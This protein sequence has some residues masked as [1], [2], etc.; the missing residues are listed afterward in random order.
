[1][2]RR[3]K[4]IIIASF[5]LAFVTGIASA[6]V[7][8]T[9]KVNNADGS[10][11]T[12]N[13]NLPTTVRNPITGK[14]T[15]TGK[16]APKTTS[17]STTMSTTTTTVSTN[18]TVPTTTNTP[19]SVGLMGW[20]V[21]AS[22][23][24]LAAKGLSCNLLQ[25]YSGPSK[26]QAGQTYSL[27]RFEQ[28]VDL[29]A[30]NVIL[31]RVCVRPRNQ[32]V[33]GSLVST[34]V[35]APSGDC[36]FYGLP[37]GTTATV[38]DSEIDGS[39]IAS[40]DIA[41]A[42]GFDGAANLYRNYVHHTGSGIAL[43]ETGTEQSFVVEN[44]YVHMLRHAGD[45]HHDGATVRDFLKN[46]NNTRTLLWKNN[47]F[48]SRNDSGEWETAAF[49]LQPTWSC[50]SINN[51]RLEGNLFEGRAYNL[52]LEQHNG[53]HTNS[54]AVNNRFWQPSGCDPQSCYGHSLVTGS[55]GWAVWQDNYEYDSTR[56]DG[57]GA[58]VLP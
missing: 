15:W 27:L 14:C 53:G 18:T 56:S 8:A 19:P 2:K 42:N 25:L 37:P 30:G 24:G 21:N 40:G 1:M 46:S 58:P 57:K 36:C 29:S 33:L 34:T 35:Y 12:V 4:A 28:Y 45:A 39:L 26:L 38:K 11:I 3:S 32:G 23:V 49:V 51:V 7:L 20:Q 16:P 55:P 50:C 43:R 9:F 22:T 10:T 44:N 6:A 52:T 41:K 13:C 54:Q 5:S 17:T 31:D 48:D 47:R